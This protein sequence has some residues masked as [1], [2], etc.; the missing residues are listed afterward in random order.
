MADTPAP[1]LPGVEVP[2]VPG[3]IDPEPVGVLGEQIVDV[4]PVQP[5]VG[6][7]SGVCVSS[8]VTA[9]CFRTRAATSSKLGIT[10]LRPTPKP[11]NY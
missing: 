7:E 10:F 8:P 9:A 4:V 3:Q 2:D 11:L 6:L 1:F 5:E